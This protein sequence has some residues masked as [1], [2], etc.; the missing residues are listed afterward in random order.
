MTACEAD[1]QKMVVLPDA[2]TYP[3][4]MVIKAPDAAGAVMAMPASEQLP[5]PTKFTPSARVWPLPPGGLSAISVTAS[6]QHW[7]IQQASV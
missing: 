1:S 5:S 2:G 6:L 7:P 3:A 4:T